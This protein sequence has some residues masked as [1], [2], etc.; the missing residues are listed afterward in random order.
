LLLQIISFYKESIF[1]RESKNKEFSKDFYF[2]EMTREDWSNDAENSAF[3]K[4]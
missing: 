2:K 3:K 1:K 4:H